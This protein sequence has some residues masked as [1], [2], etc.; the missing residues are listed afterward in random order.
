MTLIFAD[1]LGWG[2]FADAEGGEDDIEDLL[3]VGMADDVAEGLQGFAEVEG[4]ELGGGGGLEG[5]LGGGEVGFD[6]LEAVFVAGVDG[7]GVV[8]AEAA[9]TEDDALDGGAELI[10]AAGG[11]AGE[12]EGVWSWGPVWVEAEVAFIE[13]N[14]VALAGGGGDGDAG[15]G[16]GGE[17]GIDD[18]DDEVGA[19]EFLVGALD[20]DALDFVATFAEAGGID[21]AEGDAVDLDDFLDGVAGGAGGG[22]DD[23]AL[24]AE[25]AIEQAAFAD[26]GLADDDGAGAVAEDAALLGGV[27]E[28]A[29][30]GDEVGEACLK[31]GAGVWGDVFFGEVDVGLD[32]GEDVD[33][34][35][36]EGVGFLADGAGELLVGGAEGESA[37]GVDEVHDGLGLGEVDF[38]V[39]EGALGELAGFSGAGSGLEEGFEDALGDEHTAVAVEFDDG[40][41]GVAGGG[42]E[43]EGDALIEGEALGVHG[44]G[45][46]GEA[47]GPVGQG[48]AGA[49]DFGGDGDGLGAGQ[50]D[51][52]DG[53]LP[54]G[55]GD[56]GDGV[57]HHEVTC[58]GRI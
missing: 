48:F 25:Q 16:G 19:F 35:S 42:A 26:V 23:G 53:R 11:G 8:G 10:D 39:E 15:G 55:G 46:V 12:G 28:A 52:A 33:E 29:G 30:A 7:D 50:T 47:W 14:E 44:L 18:F 38:A 57:G 5:G 51:D 20:A 56:G 36:A 37:L 40:F 13:E 24:E 1:A 32:V 43:E 58:R 17:A 22:A 9:G 3:D 34:R 49:E 21:E 45:E 54:D 27:E 6:A 31:G 4:D 2:L 41:S